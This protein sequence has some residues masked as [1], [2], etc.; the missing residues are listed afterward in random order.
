MR[1]DAGWGR[2][3][4]RSCFTDTKLR[5]VWGQ[6]AC[7]LGGWRCGRRLGVAGR[8]SEARVECKCAEVCVARGLESC[9]QGL[10]QG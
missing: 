8:F 10:T 2:R 3:E 4:R 9:Q 1:L 5:R 6:Q 7:Q